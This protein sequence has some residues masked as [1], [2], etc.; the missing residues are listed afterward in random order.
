MP[1]EGGH[2]GHPRDA[3]PQGSTSMT[4]HNT[5]PPKAVGLYD[6]RFEHDAC[7]VG[8][9]ARLDNE[10]DTRGHRARDHGAR[11]PR[12]PRRV[13]RRPAHGRWRGDPDADPRRALPRRRRVRAPAGR[14]VRRADVLPADRR[15]RARAPDGAAGAGGARRGPADPRLARGPGGPRA[16]R[17]GG[18]RLPAG[19]PPAVRREPGRPRAPTRTRSSASCT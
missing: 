1:T 5:Q 18:G 11:E 3:P 16:H 13:G 7:G 10:P 15:G 9:V 17:R 8:M 19:D 4:T 12:A 6:P 14:A 2:A